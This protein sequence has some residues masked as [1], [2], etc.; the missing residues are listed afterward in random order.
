[1]ADAVPTVE[2]LRA[3]VRG[4]DRKNESQDLDP[5]W[6]D[7]TRSALRR[8]RGDIYGILRGRGYT[9]AQIDGGDDI[10]SLVEFQALYWTGILSVGL[11]STEIYNSLE[12]LDQRK[13]LAEAAWTVAGVV[14]APGATLT[15]G[16]ASGAFQW[17]ADGTVRSPLMTDPVPRWCGDTPFPGV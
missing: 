11:V 8:A 13:Q 14:V 16:S 3:A 6:T 2:K 12:K 4:M 17:P 5:F 15:T 1:V 10:A 7:L 9:T